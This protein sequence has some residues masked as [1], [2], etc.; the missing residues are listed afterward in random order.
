MP[1][2][3]V[4]QLKLRLLL[5]ALREEQVGAVRRIRLQ[6]IYSRQHSIKWT[7]PDPVGIGAVARRLERLG[8]E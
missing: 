8:G 4:L 6:G 1:G 7:N 2:R 5:A 3:G